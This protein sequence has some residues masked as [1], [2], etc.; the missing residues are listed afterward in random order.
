[1][2]NAKSPSLSHFICLSLLALVFVRPFFSGLAY[3]TL[4][5]YYQ[6]L[7]IFLAIITLLTNKKSRFKNPYD[8]PLLLILAAYLI[9]T[10]FSVNIQNSIRE[11][12][13]F[14]SYFCI[15]FLISQADER[16]K[17]FIIKTVVL[18]ASIVSLYS[19]YQYFWGYDW[20]LD[21]L[22]RINS[23]FLLTSAYA[24]DIL[25]AK[26]A[27]GTFPSP[28]IFG[29]YLLI[30]FFLSLYLIKNS[31]FSRPR[32]WLLS[33]FLITFALILTKSLG[34]WLSF[35]SAIIILFLLSYKTLKYKKLAILLFLVFVISI[36]TFI[37]FSRWERL[38]DMNNPQNSITERISYWRTAI[39]VIKDHPFLG[40]GA[41]N[42]HEVFLDYKVGTGTD[43][44]Y[45]HNIFLHQWSETGIFGFIGIMLLIITFI[46]KVRSKSKYLFLA[47]LAFIIHN[48]IDN[49]YFIPQAGLFWWVLL[50]LT[51][52][53]KKVQ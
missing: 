24:K 46:A 33:P 22:G 41:G 30:S 28:N 44:R 32:L 47:G 8:F 15:F 5:I 13:K 7:A 35:I 42:F 45:A 37:I 26:R 31:N 29:G 36:I 1:M 6:N 9:S 48:L 4:E 51:A 17:N 34:V 50:G 3:P 49:T 52:Q 27:I 23:D 16:Q 40:V 39:G 2:K 19:I 38:V 14:I 12:S 20:T 11:I 18:S 21:Y 53:S 43:T 10:I 25:I